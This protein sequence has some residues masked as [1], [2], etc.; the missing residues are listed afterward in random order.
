MRRHHK[1]HTNQINRKIPS[2]G[3]QSLCRKNAM[4]QQKQPR[5]QVP[6][7]GKHHIQIKTDSNKTNARYY[8]VG[9]LSTYNEWSCASQVSRVQFILG[10]ITISL[11]PKPYK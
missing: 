5:P 10:F 2:H 11:S 3:V 9:L 6:S 4:Y 7:V 8:V 1:K